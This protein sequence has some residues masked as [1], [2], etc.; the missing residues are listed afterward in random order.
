MHQVAFRRSLYQRNCGLAT[1]GGP[2]PA[3]EAFFLVLAK[4]RIDRASVLEQLQGATPDGSNT[5]R[6]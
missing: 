5:R 2:R 4:S 6:V 3:L 1:S